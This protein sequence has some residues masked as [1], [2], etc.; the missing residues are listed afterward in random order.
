[1]A[2]GT[3]STDGAGYIALNL[4][5][6]IYEILESRKK[7]TSSSY[8]INSGAKPA[9]MQVCICVMCLCSA[10][11]LLC[12]LVFLVPITPPMGN[13][14]ESKKKKNIHTYRYIRKKS[15]RLS[16]YEK[17]LLSMK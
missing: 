9:V 11:I 13:D 8:I 3:C 5:E 15:G 4:A 1:M 10:R 2:D 7:E 12:V 14:A 16:I 17:D 6:Q